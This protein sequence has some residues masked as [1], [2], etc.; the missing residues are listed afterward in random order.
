MMKSQKFI[1]LS[2]IWACLTGFPVMGQSVVRPNS[3]EGVERD[4]RVTPTVVAVNKVMPAVVNINTES[5]VLLKNDYDVLLKEYF[6]WY[7][8]S[9]PRLGKAQS[10]GSGIIIDPEGYLLTNYHVIERATRIRV[11]LAVSG[12]SFDAKFIAGMPE[13]DLALLKIVHD[14]PALSFP[15]ANFENVDDLLLG[16]EVMTLGNPFGL[17]GSV[18]RGILSSKNRRQI[19]VSEQLEIDDW[20]QTDAAINMGNSGGPLIN[21]HGNIIGI[22][23]ATFKDGDNIGFAIPTRRVLETIGHV[24]LPEKVANSWVGI[25]FDP[26]SQKPIVL[27]VESNSPAASAGFREGDQ[28]LSVNGTPIRGLF[29]IQKILVNTT[30]DSRKLIRVSRTDGS[31]MQLSLSPIPLSDYFNPAYFFSR[32]GIQLEPSNLTFQQN[33]VRGSVF[34]VQKVS[35]GSPGD[36]SRIHEGDLILTFNGNSFDSFASLGWWLSYYPRGTKIKCEVIYPYTSNLTFSGIRP[37]EKS[38]QLN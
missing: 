27:G 10:L 28:I 38:I 7:I 26:V 15:S 13:T 11:T 17:G 12:E 22:N 32:T 9:T 24:F 18:S 36:I 20:L 4:A 6:G 16:E 29:D 1:F 34:K 8:E 25:Q 31:S 21:I 35:A 2:L 14:Q 5:V 19:P 30:T 3:S 33:N 37:Q 23:V